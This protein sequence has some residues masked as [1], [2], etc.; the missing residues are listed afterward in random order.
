MKKIKSFN[1]L[2]FIIWAIIIGL[3][4]W[5]WYYRVHFYKGGPVYTYRIVDGLYEVRYNLSR[6]GVLA[7][8]LYACYLTDSINF[9]EYVG[10]YDE[11]EKYL[12]TK[13]GVDTIKA[14]K[15]TRR[16]RYDKYLPLDSAFYAISYLKK[17]REFD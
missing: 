17:S 8:D 12:F 6:G 14:V 10:R 16:I 1:Q 15:Y 13:I 3:I 7:T 4:C 2:G 9:R 5:W 11:K